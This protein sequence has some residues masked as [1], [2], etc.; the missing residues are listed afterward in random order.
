MEEQSKLK[1]L[2]SAKT[3]KNFEDELFKVLKEGYSPVSNLVSHNGELVVLIGK[4]VPEQPVAPIEAAK[5][6]AVTE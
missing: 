2:V 4:M 5:M 1:V 3:A 6:E